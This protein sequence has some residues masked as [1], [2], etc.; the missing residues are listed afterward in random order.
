MMAAAA[1]PAV[2]GAATI[3]LLLLLA[4]PSLAVKIELPPPFPPTLVGRTLSAVRVQ[5]EATDCAAY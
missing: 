1:N 2:P 3:S 5:Q 4:A